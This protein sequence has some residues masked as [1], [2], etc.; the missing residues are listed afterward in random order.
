MENVE[1]KVTE[2]RD[3]FECLE[4]LNDFLHQPENYRSPEQIERFM[5]SG[6]YQNLR[7]L[8]Y[9]VV[10]QWLPPEVQREYENR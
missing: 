4:K 8:Y 5:Q 7:H 6:A 3:V 1:I 10:W 9:D 2:I